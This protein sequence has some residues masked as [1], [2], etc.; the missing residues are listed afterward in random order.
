MGGQASVPC[1][2]L[3]HI[4]P[5]LGSRDPH[6][7]GAGGRWSGSNGITESFLCGDHK[8]R[9]RCAVHWEALVGREK[10]WEGPALKLLSHPN[11]AHQPACTAGSTSL[12]SSL[13]TSFCRIRGGQLKSSQ[14]LFWGN[15]STKRSRA[16]PGF[17]NKPYVLSPERASSLLEHRSQC[18]V[19]A[20]AGDCS[21]VTWLALRPYILCQE[22]L[23]M[24][25]GVC[26]L[27]T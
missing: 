23:V 17:H 11:Q 12:P 16:C 4:L 8:N 25:S 3:W 21:T 1:M 10:W 2:G 20:C 18:H 9:S 22:E 5:I 27:F 13:R 7:Q 15:G 19:V 6:D 24:D 26:L 14:R